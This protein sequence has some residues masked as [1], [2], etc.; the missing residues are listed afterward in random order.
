MDSRKHFIRTG[1]DYTSEEELKQGIK[2]D[3]AVLGSR[4]RTRLSD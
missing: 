3:P 1:K 2:D 4:G